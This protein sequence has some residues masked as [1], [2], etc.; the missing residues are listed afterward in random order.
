MANAAIAAVASAAM[1]SGVAKRPMEDLGAYRAK[2][3]QSVFKSALLMK[4]VFEAARAAARTVSCRR[5]CERNPP[6]LRGGR[7]HDS[8]H[9]N[10]A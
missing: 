8:R 9:R 2:L 6:P 7:R 4:P 1:S 3:N 10:V 5:M